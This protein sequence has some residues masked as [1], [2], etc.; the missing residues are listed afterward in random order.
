MAIRLEWEGGI[1]PINIF[2]SSSKLVV[3]ENPLIDE[4]SLKTGYIPSYAKG[5]QLYFWIII[6]N[7]TNNF[8]LVVTL[9]VTVVVHQG[10]L[11]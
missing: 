4:S 11:M 7:D 6:Q 2:V 9:V 3:S 1:H 5:K 8:F 10:S